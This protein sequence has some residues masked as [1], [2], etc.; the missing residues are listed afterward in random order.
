MTQ[1]FRFAFPS[2]DFNV[3]CARSARVQ[4][5]GKLKADVVIWSRAITGKCSA[6]VLLFLQRR[7]GVRNVRKVTENFKNTSISAKFLSA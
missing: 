7:R 4:H 5:S 3:V 6:G 1:H 2:P